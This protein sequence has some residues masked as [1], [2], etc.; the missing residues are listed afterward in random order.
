MSTNERIGRARGGEVGHCATCRY[1]VPHGALNYEA[2][3]H[4]GAGKIECIDRKA[5]ERRKRR[6]W[7]NLGIKSNTKQD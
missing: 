1:L 6:M 2:A 5:C 3:I 4:H 7:R